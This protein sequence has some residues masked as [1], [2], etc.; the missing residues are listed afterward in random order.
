[1]NKNSFENEYYYLG[2]FSKE[3]NVNK[4]INYYKKAINEKP[5]MF[6][7]HY[8]LLMVDLE[9]KEKKTQ[10]KLIEN[11]KAKHKDMP[12]EYHDFFDSKI[13]HLKREIH[14]E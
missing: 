8:Q 1:M 10:L 12:K 3:Q 6:F 11:F 2:E 13:Q 4:A 7:A 14:L 5:D 9:T